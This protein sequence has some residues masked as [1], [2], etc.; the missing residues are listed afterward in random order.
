MECGTVRCKSWFLC[1]RSLEDFLVSGCMC[2]S[3]VFLLHVSG[4]MLLK[5][6]SGT[7]LPGDNCKFVAVRKSGH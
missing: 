5:W 2:E 6:Q 4:I 3:S 1:R 7:V